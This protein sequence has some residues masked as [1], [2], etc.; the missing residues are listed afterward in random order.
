[1]ETIS[2]TA[3]NKGKAN[4]DKQVCKDFVE[5]ILTVPVRFYQLLHS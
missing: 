2:V 4:S 1:M 5:G 3:F